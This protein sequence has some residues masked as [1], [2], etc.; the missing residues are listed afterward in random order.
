MAESSIKSSF[1]FKSYKVD[2]INFFS[3][4]D[5][6][7]LIRMNNIPL[8]E[9]NLGFAIRQPLF[10][11]SEKIYV[12]GFDLLFH[13]SAP[14]QKDEPIS[15][16]NENTLVKLEMGIAGVFKIEDDKL[17]PEQEEELVKVSIPAILL[18]YARAALTSLLAN[19][20]FGAVIFPLVNIY[21]LAKEQMKDITVEVLE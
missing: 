20:G 8:D 12:G 11:S 13:V 9:M 2:K 10:F 1:Q 3:K 19:A 6:N 16:P 21:E 17:T 7:V 4:P 18:P 14:D 5:L 15:E